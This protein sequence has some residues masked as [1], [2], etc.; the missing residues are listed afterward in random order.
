MKTMLDKFK[1][2]YNSLSH[3]KILEI[4]NSGN[5]YDNCGPKALSFIDEI[6]IPFENI[7]PD[8]E[9]LEIRVNL[10]SEIYSNLFYFNHLINYGTC[11]ISTC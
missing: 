11:G 10:G 9:N 5:H 4:W 8:L 1:E 6:N 7:P 3:E 2:V